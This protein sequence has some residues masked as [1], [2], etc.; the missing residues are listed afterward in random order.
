M[1]P[2]QSQLI[3]EAAALDNRTVNNFLITA[4]LREAEAILRQHGQTGE[5]APATHSR[6]A[7]GSQ[8]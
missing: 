1:T 2:D 3:R 8:R 5:S 7:K 4:A 6:T